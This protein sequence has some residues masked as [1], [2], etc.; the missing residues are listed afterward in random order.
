MNNIELRH[1]RYFVAV[2]EELHFGR[3]AERLN[4]SQP[5]L[6]QQIRYLEQ[7]IQA[8]LFERNNRNVR[9]THAGELF[10]K[11]SYQILNQVEAAREK[12]SRAHR[13]ELGELSLGFTSSAPFI[14][15]VSESLQ[16]FRQ[17]HPEVHIKMHEINSKQQ[18]EPLLEGQI[19]LGVMRNTQLPPALTHQLLLREPLVVVAPTDHPLTRF[20]PE[21]I[22]LSALKAQPFVFF[23][24][25]VGTALYDQ[26]THLLFSA[27]ITPHITQEVG[28]AMT[29]IGL[30]SSG[31]GISILPASFLRIQVHGVCYLPL[32]APNAMTEVWLV[33]H[34]HRMLTPP[35]C[36]LLRIMTQKT[37]QIMNKN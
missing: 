6:S 29:I 25:E 4:I 5:P 21:H 20:S 28:E 32:N 9:L 37:E 14:L 33:R 27:D 34:H 8:R 3:A 18:I 11:E 17:D 23:S 7:E 26:I 2:A 1:L 12:A 24:R 31:L 36:A 30:V 35:A 15:P 22:N 16:T 13:G 19:E 10:L